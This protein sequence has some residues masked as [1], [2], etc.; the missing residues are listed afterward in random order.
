VMVTHN[1]A[2][3]VYAD[4]VLRMKDGNIEEVAEKTI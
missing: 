1:E 4:R 3:T 2:A